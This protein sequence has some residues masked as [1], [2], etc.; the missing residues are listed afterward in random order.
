MLTRHFN[1]WLYIL[2]GGGDEF[3]SFESK[4]FQ[5]FFGGRLWLEVE[6]LSA[7]KQVVG[8]IV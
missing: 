5:L 3:I 6:E 8:Y 2:L 4:N 1:S 7:A